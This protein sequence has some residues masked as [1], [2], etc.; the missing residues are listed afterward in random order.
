MRPLST[1]LQ[2]TTGIGP[3][4]SVRCSN[5]VNTSGPSTQRWITSALSGH[6]EHARPPAQGL[7]DTVGFAEGTD[8]IDISV[9]SSGR[10]RSMSL[11]FQA[12]S[13]RWQHSA[14]SYPSSST[15][16]ASSE[17]STYPPWRSVL[18]GQEA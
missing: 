18:C 10:T 3:A 8:E 9:C 17:L 4:V 6:A 16:Y 13:R 15:Q 1:R 5:Q 14:A 2:L 11:A 12:S 7:R